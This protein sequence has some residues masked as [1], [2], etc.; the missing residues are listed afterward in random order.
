V[1]SLYFSLAFPWPIMNPVRSLAEAPTT[2][3]SSL[4]TA[5][6]PTPAPA[7]A[8]APV[9]LPPPSLPSSPLLATT[10]A[11]SLAALATQQHQQQQK[12]SSGPLPRPD[13]LS[14]ARQLTPTPSTTSPS[15]HFFQHHQHPISTPPPRKDISSSLS[16]LA[17]SANLGSSETSNT[18][19]SADTSPTLHQSIFSLKDGSDVSNS[20]R[21]SRRRTGPLSQQSR[22]RAALIRKLGACHDCRRRRV[23]VSF[24]TLGHCISF[25]C[26]QAIPR[27]PAK[28]LVAR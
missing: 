19:Y 4:L 28:T 18:S 10:P 3:S 11:Q 15:S 1:I 7:P 12:S 6:S 21:L 9:S 17:T 14:V 2:P 22:E 8:P 20:R 23:A 27:Q 24:V 13:E 26:F 5:T 25:S 16:T